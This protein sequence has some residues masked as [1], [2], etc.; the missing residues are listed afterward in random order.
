[1]A[2]QTVNAIARQA[3]ISAV[4]NNCNLS[5]VPFHAEIAD[6]VALA[7]VQEIA[8]AALWRDNGYDK[9]KLCTG[10]AHMDEWLRHD[11]AC[12]LNSLT[13]I[14]PV[15]P[16][17][18]EPGTGNQEQGEVKHLITDVGDCAPW[19]PA[20]RKV[21]RALSAAITQPSPVSVDPTPSTPQEEEDT[22]TPAELLLLGAL[23][24]TCDEGPSG[25][26][27]N[28]CGQAS[29]MHTFKALM[30]EKNSELALVRHQRD[31]A[32]ANW[33]SA[34]AQ[35]LSGGNQAATQS[36][37]PDRG[38]EAQK[39]HSPNSSFRSSQ[40]GSVKP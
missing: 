40:A 24:Q 38:S 26:P 37:G 9:C 21:V 3:A 16:T 13:A 12:P 28:A 34:L 14:V 8:K 10:W 17:A 39:E 19:C 30:A 2:D 33:R 1:M 36:S 18:Q 29:I 23:R 5:E 35:T 7:V 31:Q 11:K 6:A 27:C 4:T 25:G 22:R 15:P 32:R 20:C